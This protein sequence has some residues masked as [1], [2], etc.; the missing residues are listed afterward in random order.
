MAGL[1]K[2]GFIPLTYKEILSRISTRLLSFTKGGIDLSTESPDGQLVEIMSFELSQAW[3]ELN[4]VYNSYNPNFAVGDGLRNIGLISGLA[5]GAATR[6]QATVEL[7]GKLGTVVPANSLV[8]D[9]LGNEFATTFSATIP[10]SVQVVAVL[11]GPTS[12]N[13]GDI[14]TIVSNISGWDSILQ[15]TVGRTGSKAQTET[16]YRNLRNKTVLRNFVTVAEV[17]RGRLIEDLGIE[18][19]MVLNNDDPANALPDGTPPNTIHVTVGEVESHITDEEIASVI[20][21]TKGLAC[22]TFGSTTVKVADDLGHMH[23]ISFSKAISKPIFMDIEILFLDE[24]YAGAEENI[25]KSLIAHI[26]SLST[27]EDVIWSRLFG[28]ITPYSKAQV[29]ILNIGFDV[30]NLEAKNLVISPE[31]FASTTSG[32]INIKV[33]NE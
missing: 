25:R 20:L 14:N 30:Q 15:K 8:S 11:S 21:K 24:D 18:Q 7:I 13:I 17:I 9:K 27:N 5:Y 4:L 6:S 22:P 23:K 19:V 33:I 31:E 28:V 1:T 3:N 12:V 16:Q 29:N 32:Y 10:T 2:E 26:N